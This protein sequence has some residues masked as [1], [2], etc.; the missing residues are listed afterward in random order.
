MDKLD[1]RTRLQNIIWSENINEKGI[2]LI[3]H[4][5]ANIFNFFLK[6]NKIYLLELRGLG[7]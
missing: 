6:K 2:Y 7:W 4:T 5:K 1:I 3:L